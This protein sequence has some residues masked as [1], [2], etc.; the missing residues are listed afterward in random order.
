MMQTKPSSLVG[1]GCSYGTCGLMQLSPQRLP[2]PC[3]GGTAYVSRYRKTLSHCGPLMFLFL[4][5][6]VCSIALDAGVSTR[7]GAVLRRAMRHDILRSRSF[8]APPPVRD[9]SVAQEGNAVSPE[10][11]VVNLYVVADD[12]TTVALPFVHS[13]E[14]ST[15]AATPG[16]AE[17]DST[18]NA[19]RDRLPI[20]QHCLVLLINLV[21]VFGLRDVFRLY[22]RHR[23]RKRARAIQQRNQSVRELLMDRAS[24][25]KQ[26][27]RRIAVELAETDATERKMKTASS[28]R[29]GF[30]ETDIERGTNGKEEGKTEPGVAPNTGDPSRSA[31][32]RTAP[33]AKENNKKDPVDRNRLIRRTQ[34]A[35]ETLRHIR[36]ELHVAHG[37]ASVLYVEALFR[38]AQ[39]LLKRARGA[40]RR[41]RVPREVEPESE[42]AADEGS[43]S[44][45]DSGALAPL[46][47]VRSDD[48]AYRTESEE[49]DDGYP[50]VGRVYV[51]ALGT[52]RNE[53]QAQYQTAGVPYAA[54]EHE[55]LQTATKQK[56]LEKIRLVERVL[57]KRGDNEQEVV[58]LRPRRRRSSEKAKRLV[59]LMKDNPGLL[60]AKLL[61]LAEKLDSDK[62]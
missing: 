16:A 54:L 57:E 9:R 18:L 4:L 14:W 61:K 60:P 44:S 1:D 13:G 35:L 6:L 40:S 43:S 37:D 11:R 29:Y 34:S 23:K 25:V 26:Q 30:S 20:A 12:G 49:W 2:T 15:A 7:V 3:S 27:L 21:V 52:F 51:G 5:F 58:P 36:Q 39:K 17:T 22:M 38:S 28:K 8:Q 56:G 32:E 31:L 48:W 50:R 62:E 59:Q 24:S 45:G 10:Y 42:M 19:L 33:L 47:S 46:P 53:S 55:Q 41:L